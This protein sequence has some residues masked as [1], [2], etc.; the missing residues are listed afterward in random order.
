MHFADGIY[1]IPNE[2]YHSSD[3]VSRSALELVRQAPSIYAARV[4]QGKAKARKSKAFDDGTAI[5]CATLEPDRFDREYIVKPYFNTRTL[6]GKKASDDWDHNH[7]DY[8][9][10]S[11]EDL[12]RYRQI[13]DR[14][15]E[16]PAVK[17]HNLL[18]G[19]QAEKSVYRTHQA[20]GIQ[21][22]C[23]PDYWVQDRSLVVDLKSTVDASPKGF[24]KSVLDYGYHRQEAFYRIV[25][26]CR[27]FVFIAV[28]K[29]HPFNVAVYELPKEFYGRGLDEVLEALETLARCQRENNYPGYSDEI[30]KL[31]MPSWMQVRAVGEFNSR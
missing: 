22:K 27:Q 12:D 21:L 6:G 9:G 13:A 26:G 28:E 18:T 23:R 24:G 8:V 19:G 1:D 30:V 29:T 3:G 4:L 31:S 2:E 16:H 5:H 20:T 17:N 25:S 14:V 15:R 7:V 10:V 11:Q